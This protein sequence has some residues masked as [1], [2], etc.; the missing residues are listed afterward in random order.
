LELTD[1]RVPHGDLLDFHVSADSVGL[2]Q[3]DPQAAR[4]VGMPEIRSIKLVQPAAYVAD[5]ATLGAIGATD[6][7]SIVE[8]PL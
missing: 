2:R 8:N 4:R 1:G 5:A 6:S 7:K 3:A